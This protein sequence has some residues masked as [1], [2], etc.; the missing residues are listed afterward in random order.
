MSTRR[1][2][3]VLAGPL[4][5]SLLWGAVSASGIGLSLPSPA[6]APGGAAA[7]ATHVPPPLTPT[8]SVTPIPTR[9]RI[10]LPI[11]GGLL[12]NAPA[13]PTSTPTPRPGRQIFAT[14]VGSGVLAPPCGD[15]AALLSPQPI[16]LTV[17]AGTVF[18][19]VVTVKNTGNCA[20]VPGYALAFQ[21]K[22][23]IGAN[24]LNVDSGSVPA[25]KSH[26][27]I[28]NL[29]APAGGSHVGMWEMQAADGTRFGPA[30]TIVIAATP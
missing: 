7:V 17:A 13:G 3:A 21:G 24:P 1:V 9:K 19:A 10:T 30:V 4:I 28:L 8:P 16:Q 22:E 2:T 14:P 25:G 29:V 15:A 27:F 20:W 11:T 6:R 18:E 12:Q 23:S 26:S 5:A